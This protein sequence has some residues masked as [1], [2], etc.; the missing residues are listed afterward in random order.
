MRPAALLDEQHEM[1]TEHGK[2]GEAAA[3]SR[4]SEVAVWMIIVEARMQPRGMREKTD[5]QRTDDVHCDDAIRQQI[6]QQ[7]KNATVDA[8]T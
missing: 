6:S 2:G 1:K 7:L 8:Y 5:R 4:E 3:Q